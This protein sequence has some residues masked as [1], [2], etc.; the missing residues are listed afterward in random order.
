MIIRYP[1]GFYSDALPMELSQAGNITFTVSDSKPPRASL[2]F[3][4]IPTGLYY[5]RRGKVIRDIYLTEPVYVV[6]T[7]NTESINDNRFQYE[8]GELIEPD[9]DVADTVGGDVVD[10]TYV[11]T[12]NLNR[13]DYGEMGLAANEINAINDNSK[14]VYFSLNTKLNE[15]KAELQSYD[16]EINRYQ[17]TINE[18]EKALA[19]VE[20]MVNNLTTSP[21]RDEL[22]RTKDNLGRSL[23]LSYEGQALTIT[24]RN[25]TDQNIKTIL[26]ELR[27]L[28]LVV[29]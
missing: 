15:F 2:L 14:P 18:T 21:A 19:A 11:S 3:P 4:Q 9:V 12:H 22:I 1:T 24:R 6:S 5:K 20:I 8:I 26:T 27:D 25:E 28:A 17:K 10:K 16:I 29:K 13:L 7:S 23:S